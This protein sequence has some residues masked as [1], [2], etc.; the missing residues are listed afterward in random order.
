LRPEDEPVVD[1]ATRTIFESL[2]PARDMF[3]N[4][5]NWDLQRR[6]FEPGKPLE[7]RA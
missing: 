7:K 3:F 6:R 1:D 5:E 4:W 2:P